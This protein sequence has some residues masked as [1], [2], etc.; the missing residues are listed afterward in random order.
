MKHEILQSMKKEWLNTNKGIAL[1]EII[2]ATSI[3]ALL[4]TTLVGAF[5][6]G[7]ESTALAGQRSRATF[8]AEEGLEAVRN[9]R[10]EGDVGEFGDLTAGTHG[11]AISSD[12]WTFSGSSDTTGIFTRD[13]EIVD[14]DSFTK[15]II[16]TVTW[17]QNQQRTGS[18]ELTSR[19]TDWMRIVA[20]SRITHY[21]SALKQLRFSICDA[22]PCISSTWTNTDVDLDPS[23]DIGQY[24]SLALDGVKNKVAY[25]NE[26]PK[27]LKYAECDDDCT[28][29]LNW[30]SITVESSGDVGQYTS[31][32]LDDGKPR[33]SYYDLSNKNLKY[34]FCDSDCTNVVNWTTITIDSSGDVGQFTS[35]AL[36]GS[37]PR[38]TYYD[39]SNKNLKY[40][41]C[42]SGCTVP[43]GWSTV[44]A[45]S[46]GDVGKY[47]SLRL[48]DSDNPRVSYFDEG[49][50]GI[51]YAYCDSSC[52]SA[53]NWTAVLIDSTDFVGEYNDLALDSDKPRISYYD[54][55]NKD[56]KYAFCDASCGSAVN[57]DSVTVD[58][59]G[60]LGQ[61][62]SVG[63][64]G[65]EP[66]ISYYD[67]S[68][69]DLKYAGCSSSCDNAVNW[70]TATIDNGL[71][72]GLYSSIND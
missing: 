39:E 44:T 70:T 68:N 9:I 64:D 27:D 65:L 66:R 3:F 67:E 29:D 47:T 60:D 69:K 19:F 20:G 54:K 61:Y 10:D 55:S 16:S 17:Q 24:A 62:T 42:D 71:E 51:R 31:L 37:N 30:T 5:L 45:H 21:N 41:F 53:V 34:A 26:T 33:I 50:S 59:G 12:E 58:S 18:V 15:N 11:L 46:T 43:G 57:W 38:I 49:N 13:I 52:G 22:T 63:L 56:L 6:Y 4:I 1:V 25:Y 36:D 72:V 48:N 32:A 23:A 8:L 2:L 7:Q 28:N 14:V 35:I 40:A